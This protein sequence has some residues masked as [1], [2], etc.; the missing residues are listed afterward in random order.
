M[1]CALVGSNH[2]TRSTASGFIAA[3][4]WPE[5]T[6]R[7]EST[8]KRT[9]HE[10]EFGKHGVGKPPDNGFRTFS[11]SDMVFRT[12][13]PAN[14]DLA[15]AASPRSRKPPVFRHHIESVTGFPYAYQEGIS[16]FRAISSVDREL[17]G[18]PTSMRGFLG[19]R[20]PSG[21]RR[22]APRRACGEDAGASRVDWREVTAPQ[23]NQRTTTASR[24]R[25]D[26][27]LRSGSQRCPESRD[28]RRRSTPASRRRAASLNSLAAIR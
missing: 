14:L 22:G 16:L 13:N 18:F 4:A 15:K 12:R 27:R 3:T 19:A 23:P 9:N 21:E 8:H 5:V 28:G 7:L 2:S 26:H 20:S 11:Q 25:L 17:T 6:E 10:R 1:N 24:F